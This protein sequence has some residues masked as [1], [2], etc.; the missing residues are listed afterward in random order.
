MIVFSHVFSMVLACGSSL[1]GKGRPYS[2]RTPQ[3]GSLRCPH[4]HAW[5]AWRSRTLGDSSSIESECRFCSKHSVTCH[6]YSSHTFFKANISIERPQQSL[7]RERFL[8][9]GLRCSRPITSCARP[10]SQSTVW[11]ALICAETSS[12]VKTSCQWS[13]SHC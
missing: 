7:Q 4:R 11:H 8:E 6:C 9:S 5:F 3:P 2:C 13:N 1:S 12:W 10:C